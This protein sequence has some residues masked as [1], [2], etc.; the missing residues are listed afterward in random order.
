[1]NF[2]KK[3]FVPIF[4]VFIAI[5]CG[6]KDSSSGSSL[7]FAGAA[8]S[9]AQQSISAAGAE[10]A[11]KK[12]LQ[13]LSSSMG[14][15]GIKA[16]D[17]HCEGMGSDATSS[18]DFIGCILQNNDGSPETV[19][20]SLGQ[21]NQIITGIESRMT[22]SFPATPLISDE[23]TFNLTTADGT[24]TPTI[25]IRESAGNGSP[26]TEVIDVCIINLTIPNGPTI[27]NTI[28]DCVNDGFT[29]TIQLRSNETQLGF[30]TI[31]RI[32]PYEVV[33]FLIDKSTDKLR[34]ESW[35]FNNGYHTRGY[36][37]GNVST[38]LILETVTGVRF[39][40]AFS[41]GGNWGGIYGAY[42]GTNICMNYESSA[43]VDDPQAVGTCSSYP[44]YDSGFDD[45]SGAVA[46]PAWADNSAKGLLN[47]DDSAFNESSIFIDN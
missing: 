22:L 43:S 16:F 25:A 40:S 35:S 30:R 41:N 8:F 46:F 32:G 11:S 5:G 27:S 34:F 17:P 44:E 13:S 19:L 14:I 45:F 20:G 6:K 29:Y 18:A 23:M 28:D 26:W 2:L 9:K 15:E 1:M 31:S 38:S 47:F 36:V 33:S 42:D 3:S 24:M 7:G 39:A 21:V 12:I 4:I 37:T 10:L